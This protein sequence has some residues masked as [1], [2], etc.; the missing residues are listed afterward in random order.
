MEI[1]YTPGL[2]SLTFRFLMFVPFPIAIVSFLKIWPFISEMVISAFLA[3][4]SDTNE[5]L[6]I[7][8]AGF[9]AIIMLAARRR[10]FT[11]SDRQD[12]IV[13]NIGD[14][15]FNV[16]FIKTSTIHTAAFDNKIF[17]AT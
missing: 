13:S 6:R 2:N 7:D 3:S 10:P 12:K 5:I 9:G 8:C 17:I 14:N 11:K 16:G 4:I 15:I 1:I